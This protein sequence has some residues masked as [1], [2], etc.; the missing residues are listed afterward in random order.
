[1]TPID[2]E[3]IAM[4]LKGTTRSPVHGR[5]TFVHQRTFAVVVNDHTLH[6]RLSTADQAALL[7]RQPELFERFAGRAPMGV[8]VVKLD[9]IDGETLA[10][11]IEMA[12]R[13]GPT[14]AA[15]ALRR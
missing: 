3:R 6:L 15:H 5:M 13:N 10:T 4:G 2:V 1:M 7:D 14:S 12:W 8:T 9:K 11:A